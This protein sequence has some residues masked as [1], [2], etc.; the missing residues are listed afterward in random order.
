ML[1]KWTIIIVAFLLVLIVAYVTGR[2]SVHSEVT[3]A[4]TPEKVWSVLTN[5]NTYASW[6]PVMQ[7]LE[8]ELTAGS[9]V[10][11]QFTQSATNVYK[12]SA[13]VRKVMS[14]KL[15]NQIGGMPLFLTFNH[16]YILESSGKETKVIIHEDYKGIGVHFWNPKPVQEAYE[17]L[18][19]ALKKQVESLN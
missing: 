1:S 18:N 15:L 17:K 19:L 9:S 3:V 11:Y 12:I 2:K 5:T 13:R 10:K 6:N 8:G 4:A 16:Y 7:L 14:N